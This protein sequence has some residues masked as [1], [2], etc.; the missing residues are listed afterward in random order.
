MAAERAGGL[1]CGMLIRASG[2]SVGM[3]ESWG[4]SCPSVQ[5]G[6][7][8]THGT[9]GFRKTC[10]FAGKTNCTPGRPAPLCITTAPQPGI[11]MNRFLSGLSLSL[12]LLVGSCVWIIQSGSVEEVSAGSPTVVTAPMKA[13]LQNGDVVVYD[14]GADISSTSI[15]GPGLRYPLNRET[16]VQ[17]SEVPLDSV[18]GI[19]AF[20]GRIDP[21]GTAAM[22]VLATALGVVGG[23][24]LAVA[25]F[26]SCPTVYASPEGG[27]AL[28]AE[29]FSYSIAA[30]AEAGDLDRLRIEP[31]ADGVIRLELRNEAL[32]THYI[33]FLELVEVEHVPGVNVVSDE[34]GVPVGASDLKAPLSAT[35]R[36]GRSVLSDVVARDDLAFS[37][38][39]A[40]IMAATS[41]D[42]REYLDLAF[43]NPRA[44]EAVLLLD[45]RNSLLNTVLFYDLMLGTVG[46]QA[47]NWWGGNLEGIGAAFEVARWY[48]ET[49][50]LTVQVGTGDGWETVT[51]VG[52]TGP[53]A[54]E[55]IGVRIPV[56]ESG[57]V[58]VR[59]SFL[60]DDW[61][62]DR[63]ALGSLAETDPHGRVPIHRVV[64]G[65]EA[66]D[67]GAVARLAAADDEYL[68]TY[69]GTS[70][71]LEF[72]P[73]AASP[74]K[75][76]TYLLATQGYYIEWIRP[77]WIRRSRQVAPFQPGP[78]SVERLMAAWMEKKDTF[79]EAFFGSKIPVR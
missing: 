53:I 60:V 5:R 34:E 8:N 27:G 45:L 26:G 17:V 29:A 61:R 16:G 64:T 30:Q 79:E 57:P 42:S 12:L 67:P 68:L 6:R 19:E 70:A 48:L 51:T 11:P 56:P 63:V 9:R 39:E 24:A 4:R 13:F 36:D 28:Q 74:G 18:V 31:D 21:V 25:I 44:E 33:N 66:E 14:D 71:T 43:P 50:G 62:F 1:G 15:F 58:R 73:N 54:W 3:G 10:L 69:P 35:D 65:E 72:L 40:R 76:R 78:G 20:R 37:S 38:T 23:S 77:E 46:A 41:E 49:L 22:S 52:D 55:E 2:G 75:D 47:L 7:P 32:E 59:L